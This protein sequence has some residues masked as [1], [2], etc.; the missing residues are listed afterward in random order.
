MPAVNRPKVI[1][2]FDRGLV[3]RNRNRAAAR[4]AEHD[5][6]FKWTAEQLAD[7]LKDIK[8]EFAFVLQAGGR[9]KLD[10]I[11]GLQKMIAMDAAENFSSRPGVIADEEFLPFADD[12]FD[13]VLSPLSL[14]TV[15]DLPGALIQIN[16]VLKPDGLCLAAMLGGATLWELR[17]VMM[18]TEI[19]MRGGASPHVAPFASKQQ[20]GALMQ[21]AR[22]A[23]P[24]VD[25]EKVTV[26]YDSL[27]KLMHD[28]R[29]M[30]EG[31]CLADRGR[32][33]L[34][35]G[36]FTEAGRLYREKFSEEDGRI[37]A[38]FEIIFLIGWAPHGSQQKP[39][40]PGSAEKRLSDALGTKEVG[41][42]V[43]TTE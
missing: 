34:H 32:M 13:M 3:R 35:K 39:L 26:T 24:V 18:Q 30:G 5:F 33:P 41:S 1:E 11:P 16:R 7:R 9:T 37:R 36:F 40:R 19:A 6:L 4:F 12:S 42:G 31:N 38:T 27:A 20:A 15:N 23:L 2:I 14:H 8:R 21:R 22:F 29:G 17:Q 43:K 10:N 28:L 25:S